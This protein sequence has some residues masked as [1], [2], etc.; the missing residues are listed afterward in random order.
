MNTT[1]GVARTEV[2]RYMCGR[3]QFMFT[4][5]LYLLMPIWWCLSK[6][7]IQSAQTS[8]YLASDR[9]LEGVTGKYFR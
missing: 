4:A 2:I 1:L 9:S 5:V 8:V 7:L 3:Y 6:N